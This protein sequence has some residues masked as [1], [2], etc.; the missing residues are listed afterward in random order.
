[1]AEG[2][3]VALL[4]LFP[5]IG[6]ASRSLIAVVLPAIAWPLF[7]SGLNQGWW[8]NGTGDGWQYASLVV[9][10]VGILST[11]LAVAAVRAR[12]RRPSCLRTCPDRPL[13]TLPDVG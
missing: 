11:G 5:L 3:F 13:A 4:I 2:V 1:M 6:V 8:G 7:Y 10:A 12:R 9:T